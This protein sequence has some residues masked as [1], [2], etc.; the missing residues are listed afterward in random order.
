MISNQ[1]IPKSSVT[2]IVIS[3]DDSDVDLNNSGNTH[4]L[5]ITNEQLTQTL[6]QSTHKISEVFLN[7]LETLYS[8]GVESIQ[9]AMRE[10]RSEK[11]DLIEQ[12]T[13]TEINGFLNNRQS[14]NIEGSI[15]DSLDTNTRYLK[16]MFTQNHMR[17]KDQDTTIRNYI[18][19]ILHKLKSKYSFASR[20]IDEFEIQLIRIIKHLCS[21]SGKSSYNLVIISSSKAIL[22]TLLNL[23]R[24][25]LY[26]IYSSYY[27]SN[28]NDPDEFIHTTG[29][30]N[31]RLIR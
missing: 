15:Q 29:Y 3:E 7:I 13:E 23:A 11:N 25:I 5:Q 24:R 9:N 10:S 2:T 28:A 20:Q 26:H 17:E 21:L 18:Y 31:R 19:I 30:I 4:T 14:Q 27:D 12:V 6:D 16:I 22:E 1:G 8:R